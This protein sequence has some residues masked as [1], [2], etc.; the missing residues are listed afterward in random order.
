[1]KQLN[2]LF[3]KLV[4]NHLN[5]DWISGLIKSND[6]DLYVH[7]K[8]DSVVPGF[9]DVVLSLTDF[10][11]DGVLFEVNAYEIASEF[12]DVLVKKYR[13]DINFDTFGYI[14]VYFNDELIIKN[15]YDLKDFE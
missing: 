1:M 12:Y 14:H 11:G 3:L 9:T 2:E 13:R 6:Y 15:I 7:V 5:H 8:E 10:S 4:D